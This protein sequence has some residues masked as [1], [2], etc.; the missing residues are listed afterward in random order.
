M[1]VDRAEEDIADLKTRVDLAE[2][3]GRYVALQPRG[4][5]LWARC[6]F[7]ADRTPSFKVDVRRQR[8]RCFGCGAGGD[9]LDFLAAAENLDAG[10][11]LRLLRE[12]VGV[13]P[14]GPRRPSPAALPKLEGP[15]PRTE[16]NRILAQDIWRQ[17]GDIPEEGMA[18]TYL[19]EGRGLSRWDGDRLRWHPSCPWKGGVAGCLI[20]PINDHESGLVVGVWRILPAPGGKAERR[21]LGPTRSNCSRLYPA[22]GPAVA[23]VEGV[24]DAIAAH[25]L[26]GLPAWAALSAGN[27]ADLVLPARL[28]EVAIL[29]D[30][31]DAGRGGAHALAG[32]LR[33][34][35]REARVL[36]PTAGKDPNDVL[37]AGRAA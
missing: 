5:D 20:A 30:A 9:V 21:G 31:D 29:A 6:P 17:T 37:R 2:V 35:G 26:T 19:S 13:A 8:W 22:P 27:M 4:G 12:M 25:E 18:R 1:A 11:A 3:A 10:A 16:R 14:P 36:R 23:I 28:V 15:D 7:H 34:E 32:R 24:E 33:A